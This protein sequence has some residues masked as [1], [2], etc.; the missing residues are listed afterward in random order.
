VDADTHDIVV[1]KMTDNNEGDGEIAEGM[2]DQVI[3]RIEK[4]Y[5]D[6]AYDGQGFRKKIYEKQGKCIVPP[7]RNATYKGAKEGHQRE[8]DKALAEIQGLGGGEEGRKLWKALTGYHVRS[9]GET[10]F[11][12]IKRIF[13]GNL[14]A[15]GWGGQCSE[16]ACKSLIINRMNELGLPK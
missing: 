14:K 6:G 16:C 12:R 8:R 1:Y 11:S 2:L 10:C 5:G 4:V 3:G 7:P 15:R 13:G 9:L